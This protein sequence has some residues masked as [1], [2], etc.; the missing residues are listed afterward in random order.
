MDF[1]NVNIRKYQGG[2]NMKKELK[3]M[4]L[5]KVGEI[6]NNSLKLSANSTCTFVT[7]QSKLPKNI[8]KFKKIK[9]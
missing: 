3:P 6:A 7:H 9:E 4:V 2:Y 5:K 1:Y 8:D